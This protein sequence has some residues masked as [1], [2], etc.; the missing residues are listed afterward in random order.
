MNFHIKPIT[1]N[2]YLFVAFVLFM[3]WAYA[4]DVEEYKAVAEDPCSYCVAYGSCVD[5]DD[6]WKE[7]GIMNES[8]FVYWPSQNVTEE[9]V[10]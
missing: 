5:G 1:I 2:G 4:Q 7:D 8:G 9:G 6:W 10:I 3:S